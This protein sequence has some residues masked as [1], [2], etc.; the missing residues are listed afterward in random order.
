MVR[1]GSLCSGSHLPGSGCQVAA[2]VIAEGAF[3]SRKRL[4]KTMLPWNRQVGFNRGG[5]YGRSKGQG[6]GGRFAHV[7]G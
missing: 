7:V 4:S 1:G 3:S 6:Y 5:E 2:V